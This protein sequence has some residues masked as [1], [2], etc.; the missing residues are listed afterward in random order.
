MGAISVGKCQHNAHQVLS[1]I[2]IIITV[3][4]FA[5]V[6]AFVISGFA[7][8]ST[9]TSRQRDFN[10]GGSTVTVIC[11]REILKPTAQTLRHT[12]LLVYCVLQARFHRQ[13]SPTTTQPVAEP[14]L[15]AGPT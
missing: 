14:L 12:V 1:A 3:A 5:S 11:D 7:I 4:G 2:V 9:V 6:F 10:I 13:T 8:A 15:P